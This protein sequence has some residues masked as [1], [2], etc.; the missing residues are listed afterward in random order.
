MLFVDCSPF[1]LPCLQ[2]FKTAT[3]A[4]T[5]KLNPRQ[6][7]CSAFDVIH[8][9]ATL[10]FLLRGRTL[11]WKMLKCWVVYEHKMLFE[12]LW[13]YTDFPVWKLHICAGILDFTVWLNPAVTLHFEKKLQQTYTLSKHWI[14][15][16]NWGQK[17]LQVC[18]FYVYLSWWVFSFDL[19]MSAAIVLITRWSLKSLLGS[20]KPK[21]CC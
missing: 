4:H 21:R 13:I 6:I 11:I 7:H 10:E 20:Q 8:S 5:S 17:N 9:R 14:R 12:S 15:P 18:S 3:Q 1:L 19:P 2:S 16:N